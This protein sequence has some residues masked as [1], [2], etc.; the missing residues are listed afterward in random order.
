MLD[1]HEKF[2]GDIMGWFRYVVLALLGL[3]LVGCGQNASPK[4]VR[5]VAE[6]SIAPTHVSGPRVA[7]IIANGTYQ[8]V[9]PLKNPVADA[10]LIGN[11]LQAAGYQVFEAKNATRAVL[12]RA[13][14]DFRDKAETSSVAL[15]YY[16]GHG[17]ESAGKNWLIPI[18]ARL[19]DERDLTVEAVELDGTVLTT[20]EGAKGLRIVI[21]DACRDNPFAR[22]MRRIGGGKRSLSRGLAV[23]DENTVGDTLVVYAAKAGSTAEDGEANNS[24]FALSFA[25]RI[26]E[27]GVDVQILFRRV[28]DDVLRATG[29]QQ[30]PYQYGSLRGE[31]LYLVPPTAGREEAEVTPAS[32]RDKVTGPDETEGRDVTDCA[33]CP[34]LVLVPG[35]SFLMG[36]PED[37]VGRS[38]NEGP[39]HRVMVQ[40]FFAGKYE[41]TFDDWDA[42]AHAGRCN[43]YL[44][45]DGGW[46]RGKRPVI[47]VGL[48]QIRLYLSW[49]SEISGRRY[50]LLTEAEWEYAARAGSSGPFSWGGTIS[51]DLANYN[52]N[53]NYNGGPR[54]ADLNSTVEVGAYPPNAFGLFDMHGNVF[55]RVEDCFS[56][57]YVGVP[58]NGSANLGFRCENRV[59]RGGS[60]FSHPNELR[61]SSRLAIS[62]VHTATTFGFRVARTP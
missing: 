5:A 18:D 39:Q 11:S 3:L 13:L 41:V 2:C 28:R 29:N 48:G 12:I 26:P 31:A 38:P 23:V 52:A 4:A 32:N 35:G 8:N 27:P 36:S 15:V 30:E 7:L 44:P 49:L 17:M 40:P 50:R 55:E 37:E 56:K 57:S 51:S 10:E 47:N 21:L 62:S 59:L 20:L 24:P 53:G 60:F 25:R 42:C 46:G 34:P 16:A 9:D 6:A 1:H 61:V 43:G 14:Q 22:S 33:L 19:R 54:G 45:S 58:S